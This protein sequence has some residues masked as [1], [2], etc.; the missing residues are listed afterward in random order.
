MTVALGIDPGGKWT[1]VVVKDNDEMIVACV[2]TRTTGYELPDGEYLREVVDEIDTINRS[3][4]PAVFALEGLVEPNPH[5]GLTNVVGLMGVAM[6]YG[7][8][9]SHWPDAII[10]PPSG[11][12]SAPDAAYP[13]MI[14]RYVRLGGPSKHARSAYDV[15]QVGAMLARAQWK[16]KSM[17]ENVFDQEATKGTDVEDNGDVTD[18]VTDTD[19]AKVAED[20][21][22][23][24]DTEDDNESS[25]E[26]E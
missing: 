16:G 12:G 18:A 21:D 20:P 4:R 10:V 5:M 11:N 15:A 6:T 3:T 23:L 17:S 26:S 19:P 2:L 8:I 24:E 7:A 14:R 22:A 13:K 9:L 1:G 25:D